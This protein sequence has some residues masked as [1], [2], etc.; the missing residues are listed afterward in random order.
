MDAILKEFKAKLRQ[1]AEDARFSFTH[2]SVRQVATATSLCIS[3]CISSDL[4]ALQT[5][6]EDTNLQH[7]QQDIPIA[8][9]STTVVT[10]PR[11]GAVSDES[12]ARVDQ[13]EAFRSFGEQT[14]S[15][16]VYQ[17]QR[18]SSDV[19]RQTRFQSETDADYTA[20]FVRPVESGAHQLKPVPNPKIDGHASAVQQTSLTRAT[21]TGPVSLQSVPPEAITDNAPF[22][23]LTGGK[24]A[25]DPLAA[26]AAERIQAGT[27]TTEQFITMLVWML[28]LMCV[29]ILC[30]LGLRKWQ[31]TRGLLPVANNQS[32][33]LQTLSL[34]PG[35]TVSLIEMNGLRALVGADAGGIRT[36]VLAPP[37]FDDEMS[38]VSDP[39][40][41]RT[42]LEA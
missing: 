25:E 22:L 29:M 42:L 35:R 28:V 15:N 4:F 19:N 6:T 12:R 32:R 26:S 13:P 21:M 16:A 40:V 1:P 24:E 36:I 2:V 30:V 11:S 31:R 18:Q 8:I 27:F 5:R 39:E 9:R 14:I 23:D 38:T 10:P 33:V 34:G 17:P 3:L 41:T 7:R 37:S 20:E